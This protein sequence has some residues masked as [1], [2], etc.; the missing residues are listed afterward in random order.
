MWRTDDPELRDLARPFTDNTVPV[1]RQTIDVLV[2]GT[3]GQRLVAE[4]R[5]RNSRTICVVTR[6][7]RALSAAQNRGAFVEL[8]R[9]QLGRLGKPRMNSAL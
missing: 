5:I 7:R 8:L 4:W 3:A 1:S 9:D 6:V 2:K